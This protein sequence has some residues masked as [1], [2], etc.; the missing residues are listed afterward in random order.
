MANKVVFGLENVYV[1]MITDEDTPT[2]GTPTH[3]P[4]AVNLT[5][6][7]EGDSSTFYADNVAYYT[8][9]QNNG[10]TGEL[11]MALVPD[12]VLAD[13]LGWG[14]DDADMLVEI[15]DAEPTPF[16]LMFE[17]TGNDVN[18]R[19]VLYKCVASRPKEEH[20]TK[21]EKS[22]PATTTLALTITPIDIDTTLVVKGA[23]ERSLSN[24]ATYD[25]WFNAVYT[26]VTIV[27]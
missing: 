24:A 4:G 8:S 3:I 7:P 20:A 14:I 16:A 5:L 25:A 22:D 12:S 23:I 6:S 21:G 13:M 9:T 18:K 19:Y 10:Y 2:Y 17:V 15:A 26:P 1:A 11:E 27:S